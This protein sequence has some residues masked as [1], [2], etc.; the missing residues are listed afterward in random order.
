LK[1][2]KDA[3][4]DVVKKYPKCS[5]DLNAIE[6]WWNRLRVRLEKTAPVQTESRPEF[7]RRLRRIVGWMN[8]SC[9]V[10]G[11]RL[12]RNQKVRA[13]A[14]LKLQGAKCAV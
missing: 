3:G 5:P 12:C 2:L 10:E 9:R 1:A 7:L 4:F 14:A 13:K 11:G 8:T 6:G